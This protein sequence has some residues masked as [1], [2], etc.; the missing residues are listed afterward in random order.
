MTGVG[1][2][3][4]P[5]SALLLEAAV[6]DMT[7]EELGHLQEE[8]L[9]GGAIDVWLR[10]VQMK[11]NRPG[12]E[13]A[14]VVPE[15]LEEQLVEQLFRGSS[16]FGVRRRRMERHCLERSWVEVE[17][18]GVGV[19]VKV[20]RWRGE[21]TTASPEYE[22]AAAAARVLGWPLGKVMA[23]ARARAAAAPL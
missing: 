13:V 10:P 7:G 11:K 4:T 16:T 17:V 12:V 20:G 19:M 6:D 14:V 9:A 3:L 15:E 5:E 1:S 2:V 8:L 18:E 23:V 21:V 22:S